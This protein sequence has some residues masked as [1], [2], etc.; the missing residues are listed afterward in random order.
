MDGCHQYNSVVNDI[1]YWLP[2]VKKGGFISFH[3]VDNV[4]VNSAISNFFN[5]DT[6]FITED[7]SITFEV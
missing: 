5:I 3:D 1:K 4:Q 6:G 7:T 2:K